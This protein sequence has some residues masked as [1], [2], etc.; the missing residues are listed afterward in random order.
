MSARTR[1][2][3]FAWC[4]RTLACVPSPDLDD[5]RVRAPRILT[6]RAEPPESAPGEGAVRFTALVAGPDGTIVTTAFG[7]AFCSLPRAPTDPTDTSARCLLDGPSLLP[8][9]PRE[10][11]VVAT[12]PADACQTVGPETPPIGLTGAPRRAPDPDVTGGYYLPVRAT[13]DEAGAHDVAFARHRIRCA[14]PDVPT[15]VTRAYAARYAPNRNPVIATLTSAAS[16]S[17]RGR[18]VRIAV[19]V[20]EASAER[21][22]R[23]DPFGTEIVDD[24][25]HLDIAWFTNAGSFPQARTAIPAGGATSANELAVAPDAPDRAVVWVVVHD[26]RG[27][28]TFAELTL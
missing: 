27:G 4:L 22:V 5:T 8:I 3:G 11:S 24:V 14:R 10:T 28:I 19:T 9:A 15:D 18:R 16:P 7:W 21:Y 17:T 23:I 25:E 6:V 26:G 1:A 12:I 20:T 13:L 2:L